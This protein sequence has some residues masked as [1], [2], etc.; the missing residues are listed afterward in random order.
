M[1]GVLEPPGHTT[2]RGEEKREEAATSAT[3]G[4][5]HQAG[6]QAGRP[7]VSRSPLSFVAHMRRDFL[8]RERRN[9]SRSSWRS[10]PV[11]LSLGS[12]GPCGT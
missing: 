11:P 6:R 9:R 5:R 4:I 3:A 1:A 7:C 8:E 2:Y 10:D 12:A